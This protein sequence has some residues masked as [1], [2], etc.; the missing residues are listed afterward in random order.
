MRA[1]FCCS[2]GTRAKVCNTGRNIAH[3]CEGC[4]FGNS[5]YQVC[6]NLLRRHVDL[7]CHDATI[8]PQFRASIWLER[9]SGSSA[10]VSCDGVGVRCVDGWRHGHQGQ[11]QFA[12][13]A[14]RHQSSLE[15]MIVARADLNR[16]L[17]RW[18]S[19][20]CCRFVLFKLWFFAGHVF[21]L[22]CLCFKLCLRLFVW[23]L[24]CST[25]CTYM[26]ILKSMY[27]P[28]AIPSHF[29]LCIHH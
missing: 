19:P 11:E 10:R 23:Q 26:L 29:L 15:P 14:C 13:G 20:L 17:S 1:P 8:Y 6:S 16:L 22:Q 12:G 9:A 2:H 27:G 5:E 25:T 18:L 24:C 3:C 28:R 4:R 21:C 7:K